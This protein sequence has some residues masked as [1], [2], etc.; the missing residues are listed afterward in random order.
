MG[1]PALALFIL[2]PAR[3]M[4]GWQGF[5]SSGTIGYPLGQKSTFGRALSL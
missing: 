3:Q 2:S 4:M 5:W 1:H